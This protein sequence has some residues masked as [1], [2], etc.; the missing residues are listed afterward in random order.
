MSKATHM[1][2]H[3]FIQA[4]AHLAERVLVSNIESQDRRVGVAIVE[5]GHLLV[6]GT[7]VKKSE[8]PDRKQGAGGAGLGHCSA[9]AVSQMA[10]LTAKSSIDIVLDANEALQW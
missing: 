3:F 2:I 4:P 6:S 10:N 8:T 9:P 1:C 5:W 7:A